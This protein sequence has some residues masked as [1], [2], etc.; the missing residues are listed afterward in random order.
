MGRDVS[1]LLPWTLVS[2]FYSPQKLS[3]ILD[4]MVLG[5]SKGEPSLQT[6][7]GNETFQSCTGVSLKVLLTSAGSF[8]PNILSR[9]IKLKHRRIQVD[10]PQNQ[11]QAGLH[12]MM[13]SPTW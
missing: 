4:E 7:P 1:L 11:V 12:R 5:D 10:Q 3:H 13:S 2:E 6:V 8:Q 9:R